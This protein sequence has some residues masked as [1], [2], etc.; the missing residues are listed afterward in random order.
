MVLIIRIPSKDQ[1]VRSSFYLPHIDLNGPLVQKIPEDEDLKMETSLGGYLTHRCKISGYNAK[2]VRYD[3]GILFGLALPSFIMRGYK[4]DPYLFS[5]VDLQVKI[6]RLSGSKAKFSNPFVDEG[7]H[8]PFVYDSGKICFGE[9]SEHFWEILDI[10]FKTDNYMSR[11]FAN[12][13]LRAVE[14]A[15]RVLEKGFQDG[16]TVI[17]LYNLNKDNFQDELERGKFHER[18]RGR[19]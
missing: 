6:D 19:K 16:L 15:Q 12:N 17:P 18:V 7:Y 8:H 14:G 11:S 5:G 1:E 9:N 4:N 10:N 13:I 3:H 2:V